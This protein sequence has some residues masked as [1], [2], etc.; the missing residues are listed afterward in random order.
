MKKIL[1]LLTGFLL[2]GA[3][4]SVPVQSCGENLVRPYFFERGE[5]LAAF[6]MILSAGEQEIE[7]ILQIKKTADE[8]YD[9]TI[10]STAGAYRLLQATL[11]RE[12]MQYSF[13]VPGADRAAVRVRTE[14]FLNLLLFP[15]K[16]TGSC[17]IKS[18][19]MRVQYKHAPMVY[20]Y[21]AGD[22]YPEELT[23]PKSFGKV[24]LRFE[25]YQEY[26][27]ELLPHRLY[28]KDGK[29]QVDLTLLR[30]KK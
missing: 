2:L 21:E 17:K 20:T 15:S 8:T 9:V 10:F 5:K 19:R 28:Y 16:S 24:H 3:C 25:D 13:L 23:G 22:N 27:E 4:A 26:E 18:N 6:R 29:V 30:L 14:R 12:E 7:G 11:T 1:F